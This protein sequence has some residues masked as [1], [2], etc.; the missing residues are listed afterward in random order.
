MAALGSWRLCKERSWGLPVHGELPH[1]KGCC[2]QAAPRA[3]KGGS[4]PRDLC[5]SHSPGQQPLSP[6]GAEGTAGGTKP[7]K[8]RDWREPDPG[9]GAAA[10]LH[11]WRKLLA[12]SNLPSPCP[13]RNWMDCVLLSKSSRSARAAEHQELKELKPQATR[14]GQEETF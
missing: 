9:A 10:P 1:G 6:G 3:E 5:Q 11:S 14:A 4:G 13:K 2:A 7:G 12:G 8:V